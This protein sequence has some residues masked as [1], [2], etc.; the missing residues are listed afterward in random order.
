M[1]FIRCHYLVS[2]YIAP[3]SKIISVGR[4]GRKVDHR[5]GDDIILKLVSKKLSIVKAQFS[6]DAKRT[7]SYSS[8]LHFLGIIM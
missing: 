6:A 2:K 3:T 8:D 4:S 1:I 7:P 5:E